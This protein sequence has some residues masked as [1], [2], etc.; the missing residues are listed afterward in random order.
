MLVLPGFAMAGDSTGSP[1]FVQQI[2]TAFAGIVDAM[3]GILF[4]DFGT[5]MPLGTA[6]K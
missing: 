4:F 1:T 3:A 6:Q 2:D 5:G